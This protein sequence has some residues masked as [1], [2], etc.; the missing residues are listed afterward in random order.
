M[1]RRIL[2]FNLKG[3]SKGLQ[4]GLEKGGFLKFNSRG[5]SKG[6]QGGLEKQFLKGAS[7]PF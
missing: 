1:S 6:L 3:A 7:S 5:L 2:K 4:G